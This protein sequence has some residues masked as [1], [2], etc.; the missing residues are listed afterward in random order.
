MINVNYLSMLTLK[1]IH[2]SER[3]PR[4]VKGAP[5]TNVY[6]D[7]LPKVQVETKNIGTPL[8]IYFVR[9]GQ[10]SVENV[11]HRSP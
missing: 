10:K 1:L 11:M 2:V 9:S 6:Q 7:V 5:G 8:R 3:S 4:L